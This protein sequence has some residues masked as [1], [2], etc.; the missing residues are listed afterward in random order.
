MRLPPHADGARWV[1]GGRCCLS[2]EHI[3]VANCGDSRAAL[4]RGGRAFLL[5]LITRKKIL[6]L[7]KNLSSL[8]FLAG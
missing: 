8:S 4:S 5:V 6:F 2:P 3:I 1:Y 7:P